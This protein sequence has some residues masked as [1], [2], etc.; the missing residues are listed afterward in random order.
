MTIKVRLSGEPEE[1]DAMVEHLRQQFDVA[2]GERRYP[3]LGAFGIRV[4]LE[5]R[6]HTTPTPRRVR[7]ERVHPTRTEIEP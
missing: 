7:S 2:G 1:I 3:N 6:P 5:V 4:Y